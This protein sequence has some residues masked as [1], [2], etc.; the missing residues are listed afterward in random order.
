MIDSASHTLVMSQ[1]DAILFDL[2]E[3]NLDDVEP[4]DT[5]W[6]L[7]LDSYFMLRFCKALESSFG[8]SISYQEMQQDIQSIGKL[9]CRLAEESKKIETPQAV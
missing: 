4:S 1:L 3:F 9:I 7:G 6:E 2:A 5:F 8:V